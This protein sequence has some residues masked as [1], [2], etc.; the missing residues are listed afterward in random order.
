MPK[1]ITFKDNIQTRSG[2]CFENEI[3]YVTT[4]DGKGIPRFVHGRRVVVNRQNTDYNK[5]FGERG[6]QTSK[7]YNSL[8]EVFK[9]DLKHYAR[10]Y[11]VI[12][13]E[14]KKPLK[15][16]ILFMKTVRKYPT[17]ILTLDELAMTM[18]NTLH[19]WIER[20][21]LEPVWPESVF[22]G[23]IIN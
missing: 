6:K 17:Q 1:R 16:Y 14:G 5:E 15:G 13:G 22:V 8:S 2:K 23:V 21:F 3:I 9:N 18:G 19:V 11:N 7:L 20:G 12:Y 4:K 10:E